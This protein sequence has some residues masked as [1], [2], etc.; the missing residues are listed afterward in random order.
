MIIRFV[1]RYLIGLC[2]GCAIVPALAQ[3]RRGLWEHPLVKRFISPEKDSTRSAGFIVVPALGYAQETG[4]EFGLA[5]VYNFY[6]N[7]AD[8]AIRTSNLTFIGTFTTERQT[9]LKLES[10]IWTTDNLYHYTSELRFRNFPFNFYGLGNQTLEQNQDVLTQ[11]MVRIRLEGERKLAPNYYAGLNL[12]YEHLTF[13]DKEEDGIFDRTPPYGQT[14]GQHLLIG[15]SQLFDTR[16]RNT[17]TTKGYYARAKYAYSPGIGGGHHFKG[18]T[19]DIDLR[20]FFPLTNQLTLGLNSHFETTLGPRVPFY[21]YRELGGDMMMRGYYLGR[22]RDRSLLAAQGE[23]RYRFHPRVGVAAFAGTGSTYHDGLKNARFIPS[24]GGGLRYFFDLEHNS[25]VRLE[26][27]VGEQRP[28]E[29]RQ[30]GFY[31]SLSE[32][33]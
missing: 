9:N 27:G 20:A 19:V 26:Y 6:V 2:L 13:F 10:D 15:V 24:Y 16:N 7:K 12:A 33:F 1:L 23:L 22:Y 21:V 28:G 5:G 32:A 31:L 3:E 4:L 25:S 29:K 14:G 17:Y 11:R 30:G 18:S 8:H